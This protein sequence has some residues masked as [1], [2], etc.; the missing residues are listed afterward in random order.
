MLRLFGH[1]TCVPKSVLSILWQTNN[2]PITIN[3]NRLINSTYLPLF[4]NKRQENLRYPIDP[5][6]KSH[7]KPFENELK[8]LVTENDPDVF[9]TIE[10]NA[11]VES[12]DEEPEDEGDAMQAERD[13][14]IPFRGDQLPVEVYGKMIK[15]LLRDKFLKEAIDILEVRMAK[16]RVKPDEYIYELL[17]IECGRVGYM[18][19]AF[20]LYNQ[21][22]KRHL[23]PRSPVFA[24]LFNACANS[25]EPIKALTQARNVRKYLIQ[26]GILIHQIVYNN[27]IKAFGRCN[28]LETAFEL[29]DEMKDKNMVLHI[30]TIN[31]LLNACISGKEYGFRNGLLVWH[32]IY[33]NRLT[34]NTSSFNLLLR[35][36]R[37]C[38]IGDVRIAQQAF[39]KILNDSGIRAGREPR[40]LLLTD[41]KE[42]DTCQIQIDKEI[43][44]QKPNLISDMPHLGSLVQV[45]QI[46]TAADRLYLL[47][48]IDGVIAEFERTKVRPDVKSFAQMLDMIAPTEAAEFELIDKMNYMRVRS[49]TDFFNM[50][51]KRRCMRREYDSAKVSCRFFFFHFQVT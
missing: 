44:D 31:H 42:N 1:R 23:K 19:K 10:S 47:G 15:K 3:T 39:A 12:Y 50:L 6:Q 35:C 40:R 46:Q 49:D 13:R 45:N 11:C 36:T 25:S 29:V 9:G 8:V 2:K 14:T 48:G 17:I 51:M 41:G 37:D 4:S 16:D 28:D 7:K 18:K 43:R 26:N 30:D 27:M 20:Q 38:N 33:R 22:K 32:S 34:P 21:L 24:A 5:D